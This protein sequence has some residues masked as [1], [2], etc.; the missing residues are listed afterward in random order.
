MTTDKPSQPAD[1]AVVSTSDDPK[2]A[3]T[4]DQAGLADLSQTG[5]DQEVTWTH[6]HDAPVPPEE[7][8]FTLRVQMPNK[9]PEIKVT[10]QARTTIQDIRQ[11]VFD[12][13]EVNGYTCFYFTFEEKRINEFT[14][15][16]NIEGFTPDSVLVF[17]EDAYNDRELRVH[18]T[19][20]REIMTNFGN[21]LSSYAFGVE[22][23]VSYLSLVD[24]GEL[25][26]ED[27]KGKRKTKG[28][29]GAE[30]L[31]AFETYDFECRGAS[32][33]SDYVPAAA[34][35]SD[36]QKCL[37]SLAISSWNPPPPSNRAEGDLMYLRVET[38]EGERFHI[39]CSVSGFFVNSSTDDTFGPEPRT[40][41]PCHE[42][43]LPTCLSKASPLF[44]KAYARQV[45]KVQHRSP[46]EYMSTASG[47]YPWAVRARSHTPDES[48]TLDSV[49]VATDM[50]DGFGSLDWNEEFQ[51]SR[52]LPSGTPQESVT[53]DSALYRIHTDFVEAATRGAIA[54]LNGNA[55][56]INPQ[57]APATQMYLH[58]N[59]FFSIGYDNREAFE[60][61]GGEAAAHVA[62]SKDVDGVRTLSN[63]SIPDLYTLG[64]VIIDYMG[65]RVIAQTVIPG[66]LRPREEGETLVRYGSVD[67]G[68]EI[69]SDPKFHVLAGEVAKA[70]HLAEHTVVA[71]NGDQHKLF[72]SI[73]T[74]G[75]LGYDDRRYF[76]DLYRLTPIDAEFLD[77]IAGDTPESE[78]AYPHKLTLLRPELMDSFFEYKLRRALES[79]QKKKDAAASKINSPADKVEAS[80][81]EQM[82]EGKTKGVDNASTAAATT[83]AKPATDTAPAVDGPAEISIEKLAEQITWNPDSLT[84]VVQADSPEVTGNYEAQVREASVFLR[85]DGLTRLVNECLYQQPPVDSETLVRRFHG[86]GINMRYL[87]RAMQITKDLVSSAETKDAQGQANYFLGLC[88]SEMVARGAKHVIRNLLKDTPTYRMKDAVARFL[89]CLFAEGDD[90]AF[91][92]DVSFCSRIKPS[93]DL[94]FA[95]L[96]PK[97]VRAEVCKEVAK[98][99]RHTLEDGFWTVRPIPVLRAI[100]LKVGLQIQALD[101]FVVS[102]PADSSNNITSSSAAPRFLPIHIVAHYPIT[103]HHDPRATFAEETLDM[104]HRATTQHPSVSLDLFSEACSV[105]EQTYGPVHPATARAHTQFA[106]HLHQRDDLPRA[107][108]AQ[109]RALVVGE[110]T[111]GLD[112]EEVLGWYMNLAYFEYVLSARAYV[113]SV[114]DRESEVGAK[115][116][117]EKRIRD[118][119]IGRCLA[120]MK[121]ATRYWEKVCGGERNLEGASTDVNI[122]TMLGETSQFA[123]AQQFLDRALA[124]QVHL[125]GPHHALTTSTHE[126]LMK[127]HLQQGD[128]HA[129]ALAQKYVCAT[130]RKR[131]GDTDERV[132]Q[133]EAILNGITERAVAIEMAKQRE[134]EAAKSSGKKAKAGGKVHKKKEVAIEDL[135]AFIDGQ[136]PSAASSSSNKSKGQKSRSK[137]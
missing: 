130:L 54:V 53:R 93:K 18:L 11:V 137:K 38:L 50:A 71:G 56:P 47:A 115:V 82:D 8:T 9:L 104:A 6:E 134:K 32:L 76:L 127:V 113:E 1:S 131:L 13:P 116:D 52:E 128:F 62:V 136:A 84:T 126:H 129:A 42:H 15:L 92:S 48:R 64:T 21:Q 80:E 45:Q 27:A 17:E 88:V 14:E 24:S 97:G 117:G 57:E 16:G 35:D 133:N 106:L 100:C 25:G 110:R 78:T 125:V 75:I 99:F 109:R 31:R 94:P 4:P 132:R 5:D 81:E 55:L 41:K 114:G 60:H 95:S 108:D 105:Y 63:L 30:G 51:A 19:R 12:T 72:T 59:I 121:H 111:L 26:S 58:N 66:I 3:A 103:K 36:R 2:N 135:V 120:M 112:N 101:Y 86:R 89:S 85:T 74:K 96:T 49:L 61:L 73:E 124:T 43:N 102:A 107:I 119:A 37:K 68:K 29:A 79:E 87:A 67:L 10:V 22:H 33:L 65:Q 46:L 40:S 69:S 39:T 91:E 90:V 77:E 23:S 98:R 118:L 123:L 83:E 44:S 7:Q 122:S 34:V 70:L 20:F 28:P